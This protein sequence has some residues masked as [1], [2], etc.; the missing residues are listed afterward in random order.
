VIKGGVPGEDGGRLDGCVNDESVILRPTGGHRFGNA[1]GGVGLIVLALSPY[2]DPRA[3]LPEPGEPGFESAFIV[4]LT[5]RSLM[6][7][8]G[9]VLAVR[10]FRAA[11][12]VR[13]DEVILRGTLRTRRIPRPLVKALTTR[14]P[15]LEW[16]DPTSRRQR[17]RLSMFHGDEGA[18]YVTALGEVLGR[19]VT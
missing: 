1:M 6:L 7:L 4:H 14:P 2:R 8:A 13:D 18:R 10:G 17:T 16:T 5:L 11:V 12:V 9:I 15:A 19:R 3:P